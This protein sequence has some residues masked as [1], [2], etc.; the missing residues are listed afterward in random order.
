MVL[1]FNRQ[2]FSEHLLS[3]QCQEFNNEFYMFLDFK[4]LVVMGEVA[5]YLTVKQNGISVV[6]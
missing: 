5:T 4:E 2:M 6:M 1:S 3:F